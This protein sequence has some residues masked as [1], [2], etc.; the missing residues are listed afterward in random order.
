MSAI[1]AARAPTLPLAIRAANRAARWAR[2]VGVEAVSLREE[3]LIRA[4][5]RAAGSDDFGPEPFL[6]P[7]R[8]MRNRLR[9]V[10]ARRAHPE[11]AS[12]VVHQPIVVV[13][14]PRTGST[15]LH[16]ILARD[17]ASRAPHTWECNATCPAPEAA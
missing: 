10:A 4:A 7:L 15:I 14:L 9:L 8:M 12:V 5:V 11:I 1:P 13:G 3:S 6:A 16:D 17:P 2:A